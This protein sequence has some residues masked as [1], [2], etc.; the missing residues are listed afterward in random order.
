MLPKV[1]V[2]LLQKMAFEQS[3]ARDPAD[4]LYALQANQN[5]SNAGMRA[6]ACCTS[7]FSAGTAAISAAEFVRVQSQIASALF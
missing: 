3:P 7:P 2:L 4:R 5:S 1:I 6:D